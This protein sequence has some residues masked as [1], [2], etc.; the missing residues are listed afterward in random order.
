MR[1]RLSQ[2]QVDTMCQ[3]HLLWLE[4]K[5]GGEQADF[6]HKDVSY[7]S[8]SQKRLSQ[9]LFYGARCQA[10]DFGRSEIAYAAFNGAVCTGANFAHSSVLEC[11]FT[12]ARLHSAFFGN[13]TC[14]GTNFQRANCTYAF[15][16]GAL[17]YKADF[18]YARLACA[19]LLGA[20]CRLTQFGSADLTAANFDG[21][22]FV[23]VNF[24]GAELSW[25]SHWL[26]TDLLRKQAV[27]AEQQRAVG[28][29]ALKNDWCWPQF[30][31]HYH[32][33]KDLKA[34]ARGVLRPYSYVSAPAVTVSRFLR[35]E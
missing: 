18:R 3:K 12:G 16:T 31:S 7:L 30:L 21:A 8:L 26:L 1:M 22:R 11:D 28:H 25:S 32:D 17:L 23:E 27:T 35:E 4:G 33:D 34:W 29:I 15:F 19:A 2:A 13:A 20:N 5:E 10:M 6:S 9:A 14:S 24:D